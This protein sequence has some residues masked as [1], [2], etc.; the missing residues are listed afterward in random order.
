MPVT[1]EA[2]LESSVAALAAGTV[3]PFVEL[4]AIIGG[5]RGR[6]PPGSSAG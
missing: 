1:A 6:L 3:D 4:R 5:I 2:T